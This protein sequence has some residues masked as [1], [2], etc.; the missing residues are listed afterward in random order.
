M[1]SRI[2][3]LVAGLM[4]VL[5]VPALFAQSGL[6]PKV[7]NMP[8]KGPE[9]GPFRIESP[10]FP[11]NGMIPR[12]FTLD[13][14]NVSPPIFWKGTPPK[15]KTLALICTDM[16][17]EGTGGNWVQWIVFNIPA[18]LPGLKEGL[19]KNPRFPDGLSQG[20]NDFHGPGYDGIGWDGPQP[21]TGTHR[22]IF[23][24]Y[25][26]D[27]ELPFKKPVDRIMLRGAMETHVLAEASLIGRY[28]APQ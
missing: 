11:P 10:V 26:L 25:A 15:T 19:P 18:Q 3:C 28:S 20:L 6:P 4:L 17:A 5:M 14:D 12:R 9:G 1:Q 23:R 27:I 24:V 22:Y 2:V 16:D 7:E 21:P 13:G 8:G